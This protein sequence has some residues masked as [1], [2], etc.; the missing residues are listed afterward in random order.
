MRLKIRRGKRR[1]QAMTKD[2][3]NISEKGGSLM[4]SNGK[5]G[6]PNVLSDGKHMDIK[7]IPYEDIEEAEGKIVCRLCKGE[8]EEPKRSGFNGHPCNMGM[9]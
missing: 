2:S 8:I 3:F 1:S 6:C 9:P 7:D 4:Q 5:V